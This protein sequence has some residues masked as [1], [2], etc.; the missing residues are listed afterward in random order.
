MSDAAFSGKL[1]G[2]AEFDRKFRALEKLAQTEMLENA[3]V[4]GALVVANEWKAEVPVET[5]TY[6]RSIH[7]GGHTELTPGFEGKDMG[8]LHKGRTPGSAH[9]A[10]G[11]NITDPPYPS[12]LENGTR[13]MA[14]RP[15]ALPAFLAKREEALKEFTEALRDMLRRL[16]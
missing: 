6:R 16:V 15:S 3:L 7:I 13:R 2:L 1:L 9:I 8:S 5:G 4:A 10:V 11:T 14:A 12:Y